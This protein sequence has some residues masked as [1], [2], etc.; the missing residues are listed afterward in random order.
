MLWT[1]LTLISSVMFCVVP[2]MSA[3]RESAEAA[4]FALAVTVGLL[5]AVGNAWSLYKA[6]HSLAHRPTQYSEA[7]QEWFFGGLYSVATL[8]IPIAGFLAH[9]LTSTIIRLID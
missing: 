1:I 7:A 6:A 9:R 5:L 4:E 3:R 2:F 8:W